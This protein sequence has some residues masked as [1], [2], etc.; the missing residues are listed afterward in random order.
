MS[1]AS[2]LSRSLRRSMN[3]APERVKVKGRDRVKV[4]DRVRLGLG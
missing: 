4:R 2:S 1:V 3:N